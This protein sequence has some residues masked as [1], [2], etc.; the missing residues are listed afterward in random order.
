[1]LNVFSC[2]C[3]LV[4]LVLPS[5]GFM[6]FPCGLDG[7]ESACNVGDLSSIPGL[8]IFFLFFYSRYFFISLKISSLT[9]WLFK[10]VLV[11]SMC[12]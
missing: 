1:M 5:V 7:K 10:N 8:G 12:L 2:V 6:G 11:I 3:W 9:Q 4:L